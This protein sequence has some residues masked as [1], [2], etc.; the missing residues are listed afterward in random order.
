MS[1]E[2]IPDAEF[3]DNDYDDDEDDDYYDYDELITPRN[4]AIGIVVLLLVIALMIPFTINR[5]Q[6][7]VTAVAL[8]S[9][10][11][12]ENSGEAEDENK[13]LGYVKLHTNVYQTR[14]GNYGKLFVVGINT[15]TTPSTDS[16]EERII[17]TVEEKADAAGVRLQ[18]ARLRPR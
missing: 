2:D 10:G 7:E 17:E 6:A 18:A 5:Y 3:E 8:S 4:I 14:V 16:L 9:N 1:D 12:E 13:Y 11:W 15:I